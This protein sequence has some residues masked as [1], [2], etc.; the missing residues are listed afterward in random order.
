MAIGPD[1]ATVL[2]LGEIDRPV[3]CRS[4]NK[5]LQVFGLIAAGWTPHDQ[6]HVAIATASHSGEQGH[7]AVVREVLAAAGL[8]EGALQCP[9]MLPFSEAAVAELLSRGEGA[10][11]L[12]MNCSGKHAAMLATA[13]VGGDPTGTYRDPEHPVQ[14]AVTAA[15]QELAGERVQHVA[16]DGCGAPQHALTLRGLAR[17]FARIAGDPVAD[18]MRAHPFLVGGTGRDVTALMER[19]PG[20]VAKDGAEGVYAAALPDGSAVAL[21]IADGAARAR[22]PLLVHALG[23]LGVTGLDDL[24]TLPVLGGGEQVGE[25]RVR[26]GL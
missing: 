16:V 25:I 20:L 7:L 15:V 13:V 17:A 3:F 21:K 26:P 14:R 2:G 1:G 24:A 22:L 4:S 12:T 5:P 19:V 6:R 8:D 9:P 18:A 23:A 11:R 10:T